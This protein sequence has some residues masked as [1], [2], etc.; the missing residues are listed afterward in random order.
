[1]RLIGDRRDV[2]VQVLYYFY[3]TH[4]SYITEKQANERYYRQI[5]VGSRKDQ[6]AVIC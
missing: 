5:E 1:M 2:W 3:T 4:R 6:T